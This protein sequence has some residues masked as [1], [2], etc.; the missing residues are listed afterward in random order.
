MPDCKKRTSGQSGYRKQIEKSSQI[1]L[2]LGC[3]FISVFSYLLFID[4][5]HSFGKI[6]GRKFFLLK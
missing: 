2:F 1:S 6:S 4:F 5:F 3:I